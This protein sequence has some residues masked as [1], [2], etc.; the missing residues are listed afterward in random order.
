MGYELPQKASRVEMFRHTV[1]EHLDG[2]VASD[3]LR[4]CFIVG[5]FIWQ[6]VIVFV[7]AGLLELVLWF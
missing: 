4:D 6:R 3:R 7:G 2:R 1:S 5:V